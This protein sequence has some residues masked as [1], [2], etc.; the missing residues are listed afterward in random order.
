VWSPA[1]FKE[2]ETLS[3]TYA[4]LLSSSSSSTTTK[5]LRQ[6][7]LI[8]RKRVYMSFTLHGCGKIEKVKK[9]LRM[10]PDL[11]QMPMWNGTEAQPFKKYREKS[12]EHKLL[13]GL[14]TRTTPQAVQSNIR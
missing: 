3:T 12:T 2:H 4:T 9:R 5:K 6:T 11:L 13:D 10:C 7:S 1:D 8:Y 14:S